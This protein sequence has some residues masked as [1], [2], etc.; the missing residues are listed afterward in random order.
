MSSYDILFQVLVLALM[1]AMMLSLVGWMPEY[2]LSILM[3]CPM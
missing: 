1:A 3:K 2:I